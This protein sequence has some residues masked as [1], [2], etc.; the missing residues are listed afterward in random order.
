V[1][2]CYL[3]DAT[4]LFFEPEETTV[5]LNGTCMSYCISSSNEVLSIVSIIYEYFMTYIDKNPPRTSILSGYAW[6]LE[7]LNTPG[8]SHRMFRM[9]ERLFI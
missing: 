5:F 4:V 7:T 9:N 8:E 6:V 3:Y 1:N 2:K